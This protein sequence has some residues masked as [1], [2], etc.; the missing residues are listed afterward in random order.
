M[1]SLDRHAELTPHASFD[2]GDLDCGNGLLLLIRKHIDPLSPGELLEIHS[3]ESSVR[4]DLPAWC[5]LTGNDLVSSQHQEDR[6]SYFVAK[7][8][9]ADQPHRSQPSELPASAQGQRSSTEKISM[10]VTQPVVEV[11]VPESLPQP[12][13]AAEIAPLSVM[14]IGSWPRPRWLL[15]TL[16]EYLQGRVDEVEFQATAD[17][18]VRLSVDAQLRAAVDVVTDGEQRRDDYASFVGGILDNCQLIPVTDLLPYVDHPDKFAAAL[19]SL[20][21]AADMV[22]HPAVFGRLGRGK[23]LAVHELQ[24]VQ[25][26]TDRRSRFRSLVRIS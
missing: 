20:D 25:R 2:G 3:A 17:D 10:P 23:P 21:V 12:S 19:Q 16:H 6:T 26:L 13:A 15:R 18:A 11:V 24:F 1:T 4:E 8:R 22:R 7:G 5:R 9:F 14:G